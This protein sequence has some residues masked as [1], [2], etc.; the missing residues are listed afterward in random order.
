MINCC[1]TQSLTQIF[2]KRNQ[3]TNCNWLFCMQTLFSNS[4]IGIMCCVSGIIEQFITSTVFCKHWFVK[5]YIWHAPVS[6]K[7]AK[8]KVAVVVANLLLLTDPRCH[9]DDYT[10]DTEWP[11]TLTI[12]S[13]GLHGRCF[14]VQIVIGVNHIHKTKRQND[15]VTPM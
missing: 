2:L 11:L 9:H 5:I 8:R 1:F 15:L 7:I 3:M 10:T 13:H 4:S 12:M 6:H 14:S